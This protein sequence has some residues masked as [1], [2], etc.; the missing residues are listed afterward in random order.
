MSEKTNGEGVVVPKLTAGAV[1]ELYDTGKVSGGG[2]ILQVIEVRAIGS[3]K[4]SSTRYRLLLSDG[5]HFIQTMLATPLNDRV[6]SGDI[7]NLCIVEHKESISNLLGQAQRKILITLQ[8]NVLHQTTDRIGNPTDIEPPPPPTPTPTKAS[9]SS[10]TGLNVVAGQKRREPEGDQKHI[11]SDGKRSSSDKRGNERVMAISELNVHVAKWG[12]K[13]RVSKKSE[14]RTWSNPRGNGKLFSVDLLDSEGGEIRATAFNAQAE[15]FW[16]ILTAGQVYSI[17]NGQIKQ[18]DRKW[19][20]QASHNCEITLTAETEIVQTHN[21]PTIR[22][23]RYKFVK[24]G[25]IPSYS[26]NDTVDVVALVKTVSPLTEFTSKKSGKPISKRAITVFDDTNTSIEVTLWGPTATKNTEEVLAGSPVVALKSLQVTEYNGRSLSMGFE[27]SLVIYPDLQEAQELR[28]WWDTVADHAAV[29]EPL[30]NATSSGNDARMTVAELE[31]SQLGF[32]DTPDYINLRVNLTQ[33]MFN[34]ER[35]PWYKACQNV[36]NRPQNKSEQKCAKKVVDTDGQYTCVSCGIVTDYTNRYMLS[37]QGSD[38]TGS[39]WMTA[40]DNVAKDLLCGKTA[41]ELAALLDEG[42]PKSDQV[43]YLFQNDALFRYWI[44][45][46]RV[47][48]E[49]RKEGGDMIQ[50]LTIMN[51]KPMDFKEERSYLLSLI[52]S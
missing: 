5:S 25:D 20:R 39:I 12:I 26:A 33:F 24:I 8:M 4:S 9:G 52:P 49:A 6:A 2:A 7:Q 21:D 29:P 1:K 43:S 41:D 40:F 30:T 16:D 35:P 19:N 22:S 51:A 48:A 11:D 44:V 23:V 18:V 36:A 38:A 10:S 37:C 3:V 15:K 47:K 45:K 46:C 17:R 13:A 28:K 31:S 34:K 50:R 14:M 32:G 42:P 27:G